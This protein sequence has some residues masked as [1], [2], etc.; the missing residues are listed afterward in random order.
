MQVQ[1]AHR[2]ND[3]DGWLNNVPA[4]TGVL[5][6][7]EQGC[8]ALFWANPALP[9]N[10]AHIVIDVH[11]TPQSF[12]LGHCFV[13][14]WNGALNMGNQPALAAKVNPIVPPKSPNGLWPANP[15]VTITGGWGPN[16]P[17][18]TNWTAREH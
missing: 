16:I 3:I 17:G 2:V 8:Y 7:A 14:G 18:N 4:P 15:G 6:R 10:P 9:G 12:V 13:K 1:I 5:R 11:Y